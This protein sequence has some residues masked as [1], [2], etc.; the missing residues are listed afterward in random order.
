MADCDDYEEGFDTI[1]TAIDTDINCDTWNADAPDVDCI[2]HGQALLVNQERRKR[3]QPIT[4]VRH[5]RR[6]AVLSCALVLLTGSV[7]GL[8]INVLALTS[9][10]LGFSTYGQGFWG[11]SVVSLLVKVGTSWEAQICTQ[12]SKSRRVFDSDSGP[13]RETGT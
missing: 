8:V 12:M 11:S 3:G 10:E 9:K 7:G 1:F 6:R 13:T 5:F 2:W 4:F